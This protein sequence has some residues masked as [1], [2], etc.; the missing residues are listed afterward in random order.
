ME[1]RDF[2][3]TAALL[4]LTSTGFC[5]VQT[6]VGSFN[7]TTSVAGTT[8]SVTGLGFQPKAVIFWNMGQTSS[9]DAVGAG[10]SKRGVGWMVG[11]T[12]RDAVCSQSQTGLADSN[13][14]QGTREDAAIC[15]ITA[16]GTFEGLADFASW[17]ADG[18][19]VVIDAQFLNDYRISYWAIGGTDIT[20]V[21]RGVFSEE[22]STTTAQSITGVGFQPEA[23]FFT[24][25]AQGAAAP[26][27]SGDSRFGFGFVAGQGMNNVV[28]NGGSN[29][30][31]ATMRTRQYCKDGYSVAALVNSVLLVE[32]NGGV[33]A[34]G[35]DGFDI[36]WTAVEGTSQ[37]DYHYLAFDG[38][39]WASGD[40]LTQTSTST[41]ITV[42]GLASQPKGFM[43][44]SGNATESATATAT[45]PDAMS[46]G[47]A[48]STVNMTSQCML[49][50]NGTASSEIETAIDHDKIYCNV[51]ATAAI[52]G[53][54]TVMSVD[55]GGF[56]LRM[57]D[58]D[59]AQSWF[60]WIAV[61]DTVLSGAGW[62]GVGIPW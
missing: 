9:S 43:V 16:T 27:T 7:I 21:K 24:S 34:W 52:Q 36:T 29:D 12:A 53:L 45:A 56:T 58:A 54:A 28:C 62:W 20:N 61:G 13:T 8:V 1:F 6:A 60:G 50:E 10:D 48:T 35:A 2:C 37:R 47:A 33:T 18:F 19:S 40:S 59:P 3:K 30:T 4:F 41:D 32:S 38:G 15:V 42:T 44:L 17:D 5:A 49:D 46:I 14:G 11:A 25:W 51:D 22:A 31:S 26:S 39:S 55:S 57:T 23:V